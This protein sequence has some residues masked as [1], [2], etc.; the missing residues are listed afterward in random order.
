MCSTNQY[1]KYDSVSQKHK[2]EQRLNDL[3]QF[4]V[5][6]RTPIFADMALAVLA[7][8][9]R[10]PLAAEQWR[11]YVQLTLSAD[12][13]NLAKTLV[14]IHV[15]PAMTPVKRSVD[16]G[17]PRASQSATHSAHLISAN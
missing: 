16:I 5:S 1:R 9:L 12:N 13:D 2:K 7:A 17:S 10:A 8:W 14:R 6:Y 3:T 11:N 4:R 15:L